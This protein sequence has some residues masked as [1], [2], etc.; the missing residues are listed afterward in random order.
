MKPRFLYYTAAVAALLM[1]IGLTGIDR[2]LAEAIRGSELEHARI[3]V[4][5]TE[6]LDAV[7]LKEATHNL[8]GA[9][10]GAVGLVWWAAHRTSDGARI[11]TLI[12]ASSFATSS[13]IIG[14]KDLLGRLRPVQIVDWSNTWFA[15]GS[16]FPSGHA[17]YYFGLALPVAMFFP[18]ARWPVLAVATFIAL[19]RLD[20][21]VHFVSDVSAS[22]VIASLYALAA[23][24]VYR[25]WTHSREK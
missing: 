15:G 1:L 19:A 10:I 25:R 24:W 9:W 23:G 18:R 4:L 5:G 12:G 3:F 11:V 20:I 13:T 17:G 16:S 8:L 21:S 22:V 14:L 2:Q 6:L 7:S